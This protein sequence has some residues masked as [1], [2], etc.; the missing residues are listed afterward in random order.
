MGQRRFG[1]GPALSKGAQQRLK[2]MDYYEHHGRNASRTARYFGI[3]RKTLWTW[4]R[5]YCPHDLSTL[6]ARSR[7]PRHSRARTWTPELIEAVR[8]LRR[9]YPRWGKDKL[10]VLLGRQELTTSSSTVGRILTDMRRRGRL[11]E[12]L[13][14]HRARTRRRGR[15][16]PYAIRK[17][18]DYVVQAPGDLLQLDTQEQHPLPGVTLRHFAARDMLSRWDVLAVHS[19]ATAALAETF[20]DEILTRMPFPVRALQI[21]GGSEFKAE[22]EA[23]CERRQLRLFVLPPKSPKLNGRVE[24]SHRTHEEEFYQCYTGSLRLDTLSPALRAWE[25]TYNTV[26]PH[27]ALGYR[28]PAEWLA[29]WRTEHDPAPARASPVPS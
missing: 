11:V 21:D 3:A 18:K 13:S 10:V 4:R 22:F 7:R 14:L 20:L 17:P 26:R 1:V 12:P 15:P 29:A 19:R 9:Q 27:Q 6:E 16:R 23:A 5:R 8:A 24:R 25:H 28:T 2:W